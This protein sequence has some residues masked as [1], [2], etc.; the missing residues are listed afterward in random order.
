MLNP[1]TKIRGHRRRLKVSACI[2]SVALLSVAWRS[3]QET[4][5]AWAAQEVPVAFWAW[6]NEMPDEAEVE[7]ARREARAQTLFLRAGQFDLAAGKLAR[8]RAAEGKFPHALPLQLV[9]NATR[10]LLSEFERMDESALASIVAET[11]RQDLERAAKDGAQ[12]VAGLQLDF[13]VPTR[14]LPRYA[15]VLRGVRGGLPPRTQLSITGLP[16]WM[17]SATL[18]ST[19]D[20][21]DF[22][23]PQCYGATIPE[24]IEATTPISS[25]ESVAVCV[26]RARKLG[27][28]FYAGL[29]AYGYAILYDERGALT[30]LRG[31]LDPSRVARDPNFALVERRPFPAPN[32]EPNASASSAVADEHEWRYVYRALDDGLIE[33]MPVR[34]GDRLLLDVPSAETLRASARAARTEGGAR[35][36]GLCLFRLPG[37]SE[38]TT[39]TLP[40]I[41]AA[42]DDAPPGIATDVQFESDD[43]GTHDARRLSIKATNSGVAGALFGDDALTLT[44]RVPTG[45]V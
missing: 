15:R 23:I 45:S 9:Y 17:E 28:P 13:D 35:L 40:Q 41:T 30:E 7:R 8:I 32:A 18:G 42:L 19:L 31:D 3:H 21:V 14:L 1:C 4:P 34:A 10:G 43:A 29:A 6:R 25:P 39:L 11:F 5:R 12:D 36:L 38:P 24:R 20:A 2:L 22:W 26:A 44:L 27:R 33:N 37:A 16:T